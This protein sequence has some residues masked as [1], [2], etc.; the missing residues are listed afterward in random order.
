[1]I[2][3]DSISCQESNKCLFYDNLKHTIQSAIKNN[4]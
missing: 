3:V 1:M 2:L 4:Q